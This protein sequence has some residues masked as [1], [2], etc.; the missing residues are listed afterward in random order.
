MYCAVVLACCALYALIQ[1][2]PPAR[3]TFLR[4]NGVAELSDCLHDYNT[5]IKG[6]SLQIMC[7]LASENE[8]AREQMRKEDVLLCVLRTIQS[9]PTEDVTLGV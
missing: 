2:S 4:K 5:G 7:A 8:A 9:F 1:R 3:L 6:T